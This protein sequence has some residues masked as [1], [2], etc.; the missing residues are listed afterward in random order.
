M[1]ELHHNHQHGRTR[2]GLQPGY[3]AMSDSESNTPASLNLIDCGLEDVVAA[4][5]NG[6]PLT[7]PQSGTPF[8]LSDE[9]ARRIFSY[10]TR[11]RDLWP[12]AKPVQAREIEDVL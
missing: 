7:T 6:Q 9:N 2:R 10:Y 12:H 8:I 5:L 3:T 11:R 1:V 4:L